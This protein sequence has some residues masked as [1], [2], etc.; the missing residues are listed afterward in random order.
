MGSLT[1]GAQQGFDECRY[2]GGKKRHG[3]NQRL[4]DPA[5]EVRIFDGSK[6]RS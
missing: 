4:Q 1:T 6:H 3:V 5:I 2:G